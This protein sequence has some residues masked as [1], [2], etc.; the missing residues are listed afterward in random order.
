MLLH[1]AETCIGLGAFRFGRASVAL[2]ELREN[3]SLQ[4]R[5]PFGWE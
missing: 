1:P 2:I 4:T 5:T 3:S